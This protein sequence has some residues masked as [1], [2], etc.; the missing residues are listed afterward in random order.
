MVKKMLISAGILLAA[1]AAVGLFTEDP[2][3]LAFFGT[4]AGLFALISFWAVKYYV[5]VRRMGIK[6]PRRPIVP[7]YEDRKRRVT[8]SLIHRKPG[9]KAD[10]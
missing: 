2:L 7:A 5:E 1:F 8:G 6:M 10:D 4:I 3:A 9:W